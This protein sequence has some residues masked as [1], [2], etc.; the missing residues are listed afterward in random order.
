MLISTFNAY[1][2]DDMVCLMLIIVDKT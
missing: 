2:S 1:Q